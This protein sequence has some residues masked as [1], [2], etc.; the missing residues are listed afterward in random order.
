MSPFIYII[1]SIF[2]TCV[3]SFIIAAFFISYFWE[4]FIITT[5]AQIIIFYIV[6][7]VRDIKII[8]LENERIAEYSR[9]GLLLKCPC[10]KQNE[11]LI[12]IVLNEDNLYNCGECK[13]PISVKIEATTLS[14]TVPVDLENSQDKISQIYNKLT[15]GN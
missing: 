4:A 2:I 10:Y 9:Q 6:N 14:A 5:A 15:N 7:T 13:K 12:P 3:I 11:E 8:K 1:K